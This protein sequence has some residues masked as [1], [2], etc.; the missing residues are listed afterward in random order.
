MS[1][2][3]C[4]HYLNKTVLVIGT[5][6]LSERTRYRNVLVI[7]TYSLSERTRYWNSRLILEQFVPITSTNGSIYPNKHFVPITNRTHFKC[8]D[9]ETLAYFSL[10]ELDYCITNL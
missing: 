7:G 1:T 10:Q 6:S 2:V 9:N 8:S 3:C 4:T 5:Y